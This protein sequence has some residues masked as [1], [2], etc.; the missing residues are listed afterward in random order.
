MSYYLN[1]NT[2]PRL[3]FHLDGHG[4][5][6]GLVDPTR[7]SIFSVIIFFSGEVTLLCRTLMATDAPIRGGSSEILPTIPSN[8]YRS[9]STRDLRPLLEEL[10]H[11]AVQRRTS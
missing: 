4:T 5:D 3:R 10:D 11:Q 6:P 1:D 7:K 8:P 2:R 9:S